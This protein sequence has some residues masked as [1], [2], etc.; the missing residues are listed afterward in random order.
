[1]RVAGG[2]LHLPMTKELANHRQALAECQRTGGEAVSQVVDADIVESGTGTDDEPSVVEVAESCARLHTGNH[3]RVIGKVG[4]GREHPPGRRGE[5]HCARAG[6]RIAEP[7]LA[8]VEVHVF[9]A[10]GQNLVP[11]AA[12]EH[13]EAKG[14]HRAWVDLAFGLDFIEHLAETAEL[15]LGEEAL[16]MLLLVL[17]DEPAGVAALGGD[18]PSVRLDEQPRE[19]V[20]HLVRHGRRLVEAVVERGDPLAPNR[21]EG[22]R[23]HGRKKMSVERMA[24]HARGGRLAAHRHVLAH[25][26]LG[27]LGDGGAGVGWGCTIGVRRLIAGLDVGDDL[28]GPTP[29]LLGGQ[30]PVA[31]EGDAPGR[32]GRAGLHEVD[33]RPRGIDPHAEARELAVPEERL[34]SGDRER[35]DGAAG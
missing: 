16:S 22:Q 35:L 28:C 15:R 3:P 11:P 20:E 18:A 32:P 30:Y 12:S 19:Q 1:M 21:A 4:Q 25:V 13:Q 7:E 5:G 6:F 24:T 14:R 17:P 26:A 10:Q 33:L 8:G 23:A 2:R 27:H 31:P 34:A 29:C 9:P